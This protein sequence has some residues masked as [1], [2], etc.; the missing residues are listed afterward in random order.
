MTSAAALPAGPLR[1]A[2]LQSRALPGDVVGNVRRA[3]DLADSAAALG[4]RVAVLPELHL[5]AFDLA[6]LAA[7]PAGRAVAADRAGR[8]ADPRLAPLSEVAVRRGLTVLT[9]A[10]VRRADGTLA[11]SVLSVDPAGEVAAVYDKHHL[12]HAGEAGLF[13]AGRGGG[14]VEVDGWRLALGICYDMSF[15]EHAGTAALSGAHA[16]LCPSAFPAGREYRATVYLAARALENTVYSVFANPVG[17][18]PNR[19]VTGASA[20]FAPDGTVAARARPGARE[21][22]VVADL[23]PGLLTQVRSVLHMLAERRARPGSKR[24]PPVTKL[25]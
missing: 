12:W 13:T 20:V 1:L 17:G 2:V 5:C 21:Q 7:D 14:A 3:A 23:E 24:N 11:D 19:P 25:T 9:G 10:A 15:A 16:Y 8:V 22:V 18:P 6:G 4:A